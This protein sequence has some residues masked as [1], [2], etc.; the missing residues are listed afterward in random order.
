MRGTV[1]ARGGI[2]LGKAAGPTQELWWGQAPCHTGISSLILHCGPEEG[3]AQRGCG[4][5]P[6]S[7][8]KASCLLNFRDS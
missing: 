8:S 7:A 5:C 6:R 3:Q 2:S 4:T 1:G